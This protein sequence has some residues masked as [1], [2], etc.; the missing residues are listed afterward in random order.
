M[1]PSLGVEDTVEGI[2]SLFLDGARLRET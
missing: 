2:T 1:R